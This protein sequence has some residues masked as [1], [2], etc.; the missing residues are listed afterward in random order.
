MRE[1]LTLG[2]RSFSHLCFAA[3]PLREPKRAAR[4]VPC[5][6]R[7]AATRFP[8]RPCGGRDAHGPPGEHPAI[9]RALR[10]DDHPVCQQVPYPGC[11]RGGCPIDGRGAIR[12][13][14]EISAR[15]SVRVVADERRELVAIAVYEDVAD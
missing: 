9:R 1:M 7:L 6:G 14:E 13:A 11:H 15:M 10:P 8:Q 2:R 3:L 5:L 4:P 12:L